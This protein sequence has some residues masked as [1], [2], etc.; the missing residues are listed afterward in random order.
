MI[1]S[2]ILLIVSFVLLI[3]GAGFLVDGASSLA[4]R[5]GI[6]P[7]MI[8][9]TIVAL[10]TSAPELLV[11]IFAA[12]RG[13]SGITFG[14]IIGSNIFNLLFILGL[15]AVIFPLTVNKGTIWKE[16]PLALLAVVV[17]GLTVNDWL[18]D[19]AH[20]S[21]LSRIDGL[22]LLCFFI[23]FLYYTFAIAK[24]KS[25]NEA[26]A[27]KTYN[28]LFS[29]I[30]V[31]GGLVMLIFGG[32]WAVSSGTTI[33][34]ALGAS[35]ALIGLTILALGTSL[36][37]LFTSAV[38]A[39]KKNPDIAV[40]NIVGSNIFNILLVLGVSGLIRPAIFSLSLN[41][42]L[43]VLAG[44]TALLFI[45]LLIGKRHVLERWQ[46]VIFVLLYVSYVVFLISRG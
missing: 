46:G 8:G 39:Y 26:P 40:G 9:L 14:N 16:V 24:Q 1:F 3:K 12:I 10:G 6:S 38:A 34:Q 41:T 17:L 22:V 4:K 2:V 18:I 28:L 43:L 33:A 44:S 36:P 30:M 23:I 31:M 32:K 27:I 7:L 21:V 42:D 5:W 37:E 20:I 45:F 11:N 25:V 19:K 15:S 13:T 29:L 35:E